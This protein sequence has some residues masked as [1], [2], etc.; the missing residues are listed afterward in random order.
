MLEIL[1]YSFMQRAFIVGNF[2][3]VICPMIGT[4]L[5]LKRLALIGHTLSHVALAGIAIGILI[6]VYPI[7]TALLISIFAALG[8]EK[9]RQNYKDYAEL[10]LSIILASGLGLATILI[11]KISNNSNIFSYLFGSIS[12]VTTQDLVT[13]IPLGII[14]IGIMITFH[15]GFFFT[16]FNER[17]AKLAGVPVKLLNILFI[18]LISI[19]VSLAMRIIGGLLVSSLI[20][21][22]VATSLQ[23]AQSFKETIIYSIICSILAVNSG[24]IIS[25]YYDL[26]SGGTIILVNIALLLLALLY[27]RIKKYS[28]QQHNHNYDSQSNN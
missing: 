9:L 10:S 5:I 2:I 18:I 22:P 4:F 15:Y 11:S 27:Q 23:L 21:L 26:A 7:A 8:I 28:Y 17:E 24:L 1:S 6:G 19:T 20:T 12:L 13:V 3:A 14:I 16:A 25:F